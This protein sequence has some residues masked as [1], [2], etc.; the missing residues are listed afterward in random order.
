MKRMITLAVV[1]VIT[2]GLLT[3]CTIVTG[4]GIL[5]TEDMDFSDFTRVEVGHAFEVEIVQSDQYSVSITADDNLFEYI[6]VSQ[7]G[8]TLKIG[9]RPTVMFRS[10]TYRAEIT[11][12][13]LC[14]LE[15]SG[16]TEGTVSGFESVEDLDIEVSG[17]SSL[18]IEDMVAGD[19]A[20]DIS[21]AS[22]VV[23]EV[24]A[25]DTRFDISGASTVRLRGSADDIV[26]DLSGASH[27]EMVEF[28]VNSA[29]VDFS[30]ASSGTVH[31]DGRLDVEL[32]GASSLTYL[33]DATLVDVDISGASSLHGE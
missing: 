21:G 33:G 27:V 15:L 18:D 13:Q 22:T 11:M 29:D 16:A 31:V 3:G 24:T 30:G 23:G 7:Q 4:S 6:R 25:G 17:A 1:V 19:M 5:V 26:L 28:P 9:V 8:S 12:P 14:S 32:S 2:A 10:A 20:F